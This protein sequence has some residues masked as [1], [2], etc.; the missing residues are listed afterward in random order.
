MLIKKTVSCFL[1]R[2]TKSYT[3]AFSGSLL[4]T[5]LR[6]RVAKMS[7]S[8]EIKTFVTPNGRTVGVSELVSDYKE[9]ARIPRPTQAF[10]SKKDPLRPLV[11]DVTV[12]FESRDVDQ[13]VETTLA[14]VYRLSLNDE[15][16][17]IGIDKSVTHGLDVSS[18]VSTVVSNDGRMT[19]NLKK[20][21]DKQYIDILVDSV[22]EKSIAIEDLSDYHGSIITKYPFSHMSWSPDSKKLVY[23]AE[24]KDV[25]T[26]AFTTFVR[27]ENQKK[28]KKVSSQESKATDAD[29]KEDKK[30]SPGQEYSWKEEWGEALEGVVH[31]VL[32]V[33][34]VDSEAVSVTDIANYSLLSPV[35]L[36]DNSLA[37]IGIYEDPRKLGLIYCPTRKSVIF[38]WNCEDD[39]QPEIIYEN[40]DVSTYVS[41]LRSD[42]E[43]S[44]LVFLE[45]ESLAAHFGSSDLVILDL[46][47][48][49]RRIVIDK[50]ASHSNDGKRL[51]GMYC[52]DLPKVC[53]TRDDKHVI[54]P[55]ISFDETFVVSVE[56]ET[57][58]LRILP[59]T[60]H[61]TEI[62]NFDGEL[63]VTSTS[64]VTERPNLAVRRV[65]SEKK[66]ILFETTIEEKIIGSCQVVD[67]VDE[68]TEQE[69][70]AFLVSP[71][72]TEGK[73]TPC[74]IIIHGGPHSCF[75]SNFMSS[76]ALKI[77][78]GFKV[79]LINYR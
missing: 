2:V 15:G 44:R 58:K 22:K 60:A 46:K 68:S 66:P 51:K 26:E 14:K 76:V 53:F 54:L 62:L 74:V 21:D 52:Q 50:N 8:T 4:Q 18:V 30:T 6:T 23:I 79:V 49:S 45:R 40:K 43:R 9:Y 20:K 77:R 39:K 59:D 63:L 3:S 67:F 47:D 17:V 78:L 48:R 24:Q 36:K 38:A 1:S 10:L 27:K 65:F 70:S 7:N 13:T 41:S 55:V 73:K 64:K 32:C 57:K 19:A 12:Y 71:S 42:W 75:V 31:P 37:F 29:S 33:L 16:D 5:G 56:V 72:G 25:K 69:F 61:T 34:T 11:R 28:N 35:W